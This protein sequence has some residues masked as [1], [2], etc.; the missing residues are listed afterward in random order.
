MSNL[1]AREKLYTQHTDI[2]QTSKIMR[3][4]SVRG[5]YREVHTSSEDFALR[6]QWEIDLE[7]KKS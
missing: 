2:Q 5:K 7:T 4:R 6:K 1:K 3:I